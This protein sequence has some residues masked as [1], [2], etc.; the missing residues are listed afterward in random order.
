MQLTL[1]FLLAGLISH[2]G[3]F[4]HRY[5][6]TNGPEY[7]AVGRHYFERQVAEHACLRVDVKTYPHERVVTHTCEA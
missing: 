5:F 6:I 3:G 1:A 4:E 7:V 2:F